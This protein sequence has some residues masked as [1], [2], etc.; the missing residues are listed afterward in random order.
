MKK[1]KSIILFFAVALIAANLSAQPNPYINIL[2]LNSGLVSQGNTV[3]IQVEVGNS[4]TA[5]VNASKVKTAITVP[6]ALVSLLPSNQQPALPSGWSIL[7]NTAAGIITLC[8]GTDVITPGQLRTIFIRLQGNTQGGPSTIVGQLSFSGGTNCGA[9]GSVSGNSTADDGSTSSIQ[10]TAPVVPL[11]I[12]TFDASVVNCNPVLNWITE[13]E[14]NT[15]K[16]EI[17]KMNSST[18]EWKSIGLVMAKGNTNAKVN[19]NFTDDK[20]EA[21]SS[22][23]SYRLKMIDKD[24]SFKYSTILSVLVDCK[25]AKV[26]V[27]PNPAQEGN[28][29]VSLAGTTGNVEATLLSTTGQVILKNKISNGTNNLNVSAI[30][31]GVYILKVKD[32]SGFE[33]NVK[34]SIKN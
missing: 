15:D 30:A 1:I 20:V 13:S 10:V 22:K 32:E 2:T 18:G 34:V 25:T 28:L 9:P 24:G 16:F 7:S 26:L 33:K 6:T 19:Y 23:I 14:I 8:N 27:Y 3:D 12:T 4:G 29:Y 5:N 31:D 11:S 17:E 21:N